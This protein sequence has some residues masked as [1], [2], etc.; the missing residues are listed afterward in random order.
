M[1][2][3]QKLSQNSRKQREGM[4]NPLVYSS[5]DGAPKNLL[6]KVTER[7]PHQQCF[8]IGN[9]NPVSPCPRFYQA[10]PLL[11]IVETQS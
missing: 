10:A 2:L 7:N 8:H 5:P 1:S 3:G 4:R 9:H 11:R 6:Q